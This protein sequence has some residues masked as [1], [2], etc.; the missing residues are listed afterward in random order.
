MRFLLSR[1]FL[2][3][4]IG[5]DL[6]L[7][8]VIAVVCAVSTNLQCNSW[9]WNVCRKKA[10]QFAQTSLP[11]HDLIWVS[12]EAGWLCERAKISWTNS[13]PVCQSSSCKSTME[14]PCST[15]LWLHFS[16][17]KNL[18]K[19]VLP[20]LSHPHVCQFS[21]HRAWGNRV[22][23]GC[24]WQSIGHVGSSLGSEHFEPNFGQKNVEPHGRMLWISNI[25]YQI[26][27]LSKTNKN[28][29]KKRGNVRCCA[30]FCEKYAIIIGCWAI[31]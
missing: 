8:P 2:K 30:V 17:V 6:C 25:K 12:T 4:S 10:V 11:Q 7:T 23:E 28:C 22:N 13:E 27:H 1:N 3:P 29:Q 19:C 26:W 14:S 15:C 18:T 21:H 5:Y 31:D 20:S 16:H 24:V 9:P